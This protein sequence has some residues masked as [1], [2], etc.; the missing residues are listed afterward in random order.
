MV[1]QLL[2]L[3]FIAKLSFGLYHLIWNSTILSLVHYFQ[4]W[5][6]CI[7]RVLAQ[8]R[9]DGSKF[10]ILSLFF[11]S[12]V[13]TV[14]QVKFYSNCKFR[15]LNYSNFRL[16][17]LQM[18]LLR[19]YRSLCTMPEFNSPD[20]AENQQQIIFHLQFSRVRLLYSVGQF[21]C[22]VITRNFLFL[23]I[24]RLDSFFCAGNPQYW[25]EALMHNM[26]F[27]QLR[28]EGSIFSI[29]SLL[30]FSFRLTDLQLKLFANCKF[31]SLIY[32]SNRRKEF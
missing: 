14:L 4:R 15:L 22:S 27:A 24:A 25:L 23:S 31:R 16:T 13:L 8:R 2:L 1:G 10:N 9:A 29:F 26:V 3:L 21:D 5:H 18:P 11:F 20:T 12:S 19:Q 7:T 30:F 6:W 28:A 32:I 17:Q